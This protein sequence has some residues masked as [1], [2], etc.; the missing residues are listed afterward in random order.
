MELASVIIMICGVLCVYIGYKVGY[1]EAQK[2]VPP[3]YKVIRASC[4]CGEPA[5]LRCEH[6][7]KKDWVGSRL[8]RVT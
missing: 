6:C 2:D 8:T 3:L 4:S 5:A 7:I 1:R